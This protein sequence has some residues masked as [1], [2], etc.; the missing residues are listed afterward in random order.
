MTDAELIGLL[1]SG[2]SAER[3]RG[4]AYLVQRDYASVMKYVKN[5]SG[6]EADAK[7][8]FQEGLL[9]LLKNLKGE[10]FN[11]TSSLRSYLFSI[12]KNQWLQQLRKM[13]KTEELNEQ[14]QQNN[15]LEEKLEQ[16]EKFALIKQQFRNLGKECQSILIQFYYDKMTMQQ[17]QEFYEL[18]SIQAAKN[19]KHRCLKKLADMTLIPEKP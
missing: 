3:N 7:D 17:L 1:V 16:E 11:S 18:S 19:K 15:E 4:F 6:D 5:N 14:V 8:I 2:E 13:K 12:C 9:A 10:K